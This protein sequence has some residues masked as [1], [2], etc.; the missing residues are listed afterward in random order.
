MYD[1]TAFQRDLLLVVADLNGAK[2]VTIK[3]DIEE[4]YQEEINHGRLYPNLDNLAEKGL[5]DKSQL[6]KRTNKYE[7]TRRGVREVEQRLDWEREKAEQL[8]K[9]AA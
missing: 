4:Y 5:V 8:V 6:D 9:S 7:M 1:L 3:E 2:G